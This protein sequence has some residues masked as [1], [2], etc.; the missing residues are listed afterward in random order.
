MSC[1]RVVGRT[2]GLAV[3]MAISLW[4]A[5]LSCLA[6][7]SKNAACASCHD[8]GQKIEKSAHASVSCATCH[9]KH[10][11]YP[12][13]EGIPKP[14]CASCHQQAGADFALGIHGQETRK[15][16]AAAPECATCHGASH[17]IQNTKTA[18]FRTAVPETC[19]MC[20]SDIASAYGASVHG[21]AT[22]RGVAQAPVCTDCHGEHSILPPNNTAS[23]VNS[24]NISAT[25]G[26]CHGDVRLA[27]KFGLPPDRLVSFEASFH[28][29][30]AKAGSQTVANCASCHG[31]HN[32]LP[33]SD[34]HSTINVKNLAVTCGRCH[35]GAGQRFAI[36]PVHVISGGR[37][38]PVAV[39]WVRR[40]YLWVIP[41]TIGLMLL[42]NAGDWARKLYRLRLSR[43]P[44]DTARGMA[45]PQ[46]R[47]FAFERLQHALLA[48]SFI[49]LAWSGFALKYPGQWWAQ[50]ML[51]WEGST[52]VRSV[53]HRIAAVVFMAVTGMHVI[54]L[55]ASVR[56]RRH[57]R[58]L[59]PAR[60]DFKEAFTMFGYNLGLR[61]QRAELSEHTYVEKLEYW[62][63]AW[64]GV[65][66]IL[67]GVL[68]WANNVALTWLPKSALDVA[69]AIHFYE[70]VLATLAILVWHFYSVIFDP[71]VYPM[72]TAAFTGFSARS[73]NIEPQPV[74]TVE[75]PAAKP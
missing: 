66:M 41:I 51:L 3:L 7:E 42:H 45:E 29:L 35:P 1:D 12:H 62:A 71:D 65:V 46:L 49:I 73:R 74:E 39:T 21:K 37:T 54:S 38:E 26:A 5:G 36:S 13:P 11:E 61:R 32:I 67:T 57:W 27:R 48:I 17:E 69:V 52:P 64:G 6:Q 30:A 53:V 63:V 59:L 24:R 72:D 47:L 58:V 2:F 28:G 33:S 25:C 22:A 4:A 18:A 10:E 34:P 44:K 14:V 43:A 50:P 31:V 56:L 60:R 20:H 19:G 70:A 9:V 68:L 55:L 8:V 15:G 23:T 16:N 75:E 40:F